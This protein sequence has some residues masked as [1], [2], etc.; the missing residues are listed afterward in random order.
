H[1]AS[2]VLEEMS[3][4]NAVDILNELSKPKV[5]SLLTLMNRDDANEIK[6]LL[7]YEEDT[8][9][10][11]MTTEYISL[12]ANTPVKEALMLVKE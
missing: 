10:G 9:G 7:H 3:S 4:D 6:H 12:D 1:Y 5:A 8:A 11:I 2:K